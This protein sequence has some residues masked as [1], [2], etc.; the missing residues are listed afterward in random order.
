MIAGRGA[1]SLRHMTHHQK[2]TKT[3]SALCA[4]AAFVSG[5]MAGP[6]FAEKDPLSLAQ[7]QKWTVNYDDDSC[8]L[9]NVFGTG[10]E[11][12][13]LRLTEY[14]PGDR[15]TLTLYGTSLASK[16]AGSPVK[17]AFSPQTVLRPY[18]SMSGLSGKFPM[19][20]I[21][22]TLDFLD[23]VFAPQLA[24][25]P[26]VTPDQEAAVT[27]LA[28]QFGSKPPVRLELGSMAAPMRAMRACTTDLVKV[29]GLDP[30]AQAKLSRRATPKGSP[31]NWATTNDYPI[32]QLRKDQNGLVRFRL[33]IDELGHPAGCHIQLKLKAEDFNK[34]TCDLLIKRARFYPALDVNG[35]P[36]KS[37]YVNAI[38]WVIPSY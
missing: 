34:L 6:A 2:I 3:A 12:L 28:F 7:Q 38:R 19:V 20:I 31:G 30:D 24:P 17:L 26:P 16:V 13:A 21:P 15:F 1:T 23:R 37:Y 27:A 9:I 10:D 22:D 32:E 14:E 36:V 25:P 4:G 18:D 5:L 8:H 11:Q 29:W 33:D 35:R